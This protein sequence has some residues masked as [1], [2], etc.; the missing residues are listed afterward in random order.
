M[1]KNVRD[2]DNAEVEG[3]VQGASSFKQDENIELNLEKLKSR[4]FYRLYSSQLQL[5][6]SVGVKHF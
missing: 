4:D 3:F 1:S 5:A 2:T 6:Y